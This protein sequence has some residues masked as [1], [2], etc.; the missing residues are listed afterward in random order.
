MVSANNLASR[1]VLEKCNF[2]ED[3]KEEIQQLTAQKDK[4]AKVA[5]YN[6]TSEVGKALIAISIKDSAKPS[7]DKPDPKQDSLIEYYYD[8]PAANANKMT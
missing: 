1:R 2:V 5:T 3:T 4:K 7:I 8:R 6:I